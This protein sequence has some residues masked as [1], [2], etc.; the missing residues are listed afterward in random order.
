VKAKGVTIWRF[1]AILVAML[2]ALIVGAIMM[3]GE[4]GFGRIAPA[5]AAAV[6]AIRV[7]NEAEARYASQYDAGFTDT[8]QK[9]GPP[10]SGQPSREH[11]S[12]VDAPLAGNGSRDQTG[13]ARNGYVFRYTP[14]KEKPGNPSGIRSYVITADPTTRGK[15]GQ[16][17]FY[18]DESGVIRANATAGASGGDE[19][20]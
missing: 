13:F 11:A 12:L 17:S 18:S 3:P 9:L 2:M 6:A 19:P 16:R 5:E 8:L 7:L 15:S 1:F 4:Y 10:S 20:I 14:G